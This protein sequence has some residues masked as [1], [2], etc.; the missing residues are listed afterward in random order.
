MPANDPVFIVGCGRSGTTLLRL[1]LNRHSRI[2]IPEETWFFPQLEKELPGLMKENWSQNVSKRI[3][4]LN[5]IHFPDLTQKALEDVLQKTDPLDIP[6]VI[7]VVNREYMMHTGKRRW[8]DKT[9][10][11]VMHIPFLKRLYSGAKVIHMVRDGRDVVPSMLKYWSV[12]PQTNSL[13]ETASYWRKH[14][15]TGLENGP[16]YF[17][18]NYMELKYEDLVQ[19]PE[20]TVRN[21]CKFIDEEFEPGML[22][23]TG[24]SE[25]TSEWAWHSETKKEINTRNIGKW[26]NDLTAYQVRCIELIGGDALTRLGYSLQSAWLL[27]PARDVLFFKL[28]VFVKRLLLRVKIRISGSLKILGLK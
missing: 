13:N 4:E 20:E 18:E 5:K 16:R 6:S 3:L 1:I 10:G 23:A 11:Y 21:V 19:F 27:K 2:A 22:Q 14:V 12:G 26:K 24:V 28:E 25:K 9:P 17:G 8:G 15:L 7:A